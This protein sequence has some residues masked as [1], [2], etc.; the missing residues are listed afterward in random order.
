MNIPAYM[1]TTLKLKEQICT[2]SVLY[3]CIFSCCDYYQNSHRI[4]QNDHS[5]KNRTC[6]LISQARDGTGL[7]TVLFRWIISN[8]DFG[9]HSLSCDDCYGSVDNHLPCLGVEEKVD[10]E[11]H[12]IHSQKLLIWLKRIPFV[13]RDNY[14]MCICTLS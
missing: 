1:Y 2:H 13:S 7:D 4:H 14:V 9:F 10:V 3:M 5:N 11:S 12:A 6:Q 8:F